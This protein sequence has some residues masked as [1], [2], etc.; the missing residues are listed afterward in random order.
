MAL[1]PWRLQLLCQLESLGT[2]RAVARAAHVSASSVS[3]QLA[4]LEAETGAQLLERTGRRIRLTPAGASLARR[5]RDIL[6]RMAEAEAELGVVAGT[7]AGVVRI[8]A[9]Q[10]AIH[11]LVVPAIA[12]LRASHP[13]LEVHVDEL[14]P[15]D[16]TP[17]LLRGDTD[18]AVTTTDLLSAPQHRDLHPVPLITDPI[19]VVAPRGHRIAACERVTLGDLAE[20]D[21][22]FDLPGSAMADL[23]TRLCQQAGFEPRVVCR[24][25]T[26]LITLQH[27][28]GGASIAL[29]P[30]LAVDRRHGVV[31][32]ELAPSV[33][34]RIAAVVRRGSV[35]RPSVDVVLEGLRE[36]AADQ[37]RPG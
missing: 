12:R 36:R 9:F 25:T 1:N 35:G 34:R 18:V 3:Q 5:A 30:E 29:L 11:S 14:E 15:H 7:P 33:R 10:S 4:V 26:Y 32:R 28:E 19:V 13:A 31:V 22:I 24:F 2:V 20:E 8:A 37:R 17:A 23:A 6:D 27:V 16:S 21:W